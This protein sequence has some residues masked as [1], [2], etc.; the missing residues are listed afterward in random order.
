MIN[1]RYYQINYLMLLFELLNILPF[2]TKL[3]TSDIILNSY[4][5]VYYIIFYFSIQEA[6]H[7]TYLLLFGFTM[8][9]LYL[10]ILD[11]PT[12]N[13]LYIIANILIA[14]LF[15]HKNFHIFIFTLV[16]ITLL[17]MQSY[18]AIAIFGVLY[19][20]FNLVR[21]FIFDNDCISVYT[22]YINKYLNT[23]NILYKE[24]NK[25]FQKYYLIN[26]K[27]INKVLTD[28]EFDMTYHGYSKHKK[29]VHIINELYLYF[30]SLNV[31]CHNTKYIDHGK[32]S[33]TNIY[34]LVHE[35]IYLYSNIYKNTIKYHFHIQESNTAFVNKEKF[36]QLINEILQNTRQTDFNIFFAKISNI[37]KIMFYVKNNFKITNN[38]LSLALLSNTKIKCKNNI[39]EIEF[40]SFQNNEM[41]HIRQEN[42]ANNFLSH[43]FYIFINEINDAKKKLFNHEQ[44]AN[45]LFIYRKLYLIHNLKIQ[46]DKTI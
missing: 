12:L 16:N 14:T 45:N 3:F 24:T 19:I 9:H 17:Y 23:Y 4:I 11:Y 34:E 13:L 32:I 38:L 37:K 46:Y 2:H 36:F 30:E 33:K 21:I 43:L 35:A 1:V 29:Y 27:K 44:I 31:I 39:F 26:T 25:Y 42:E 20:T 8:L 7:M 6:K 15:S 10:L 22:E 18:I 40:M 41:L 5:L 28:I